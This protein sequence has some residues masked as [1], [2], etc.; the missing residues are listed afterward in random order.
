MEFIVTQDS[1]DEVIEVFKE[2]VEGEMDDEDNLRALFN[3]AMKQ[4]LNSRL[5][6]SQQ[7]NLDEHLVKPW[8][9]FLGRR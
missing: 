6:A 2:L 4:V 9:G 8:K 5:P 7:Q 3:D 1:P